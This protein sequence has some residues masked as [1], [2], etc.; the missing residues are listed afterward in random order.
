MT[1]RDESAA[2][3]RTFRVKSSSASKATRRSHTCSCL[4]SRVLGKR[5]ELQLQFF[6]ESDSSKAS[7]AFLKPFSSCGD[8]DWNWPMWQ[9]FLVVVGLKVG[10]G[11][12]LAKSSITVANTRSQAVVMAKS[13]LLLWPHGSTFSQAHWAVPTDV[14]KVKRQMEIG[15]STLTAKA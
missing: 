3:L 2:A 8:R 10:T 6:S 15:I 5:G 11:P 14:C 13:Q 4:R 7:L 1:P 9:P 12:A